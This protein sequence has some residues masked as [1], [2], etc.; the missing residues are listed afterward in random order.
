AEFGRL[1]L[2]HLGAPAWTAIDS[3]FRA[4]TKLGN[5]R[6]QPL[7]RSVWCYDSSFYAVNLFV[8]LGGSSPASTVNPFKC[9]EEAMPKPLLWEF[10]R[11]EP[12]VQEYLKHLSN[13]LD[14]FRC[15][16]QITRDLKAPL[17]RNFLGDAATQ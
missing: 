11:D 9:L 3:F 8:I 10:S 15:S 1:A 2:S 14:S 4:H 17:A 12:K 5:E 13:A 16:D 6:T 7:G